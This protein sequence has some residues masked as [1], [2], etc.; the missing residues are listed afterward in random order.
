MVVKTLSFLRLRHNIC[1]LYLSF[2]NDV[3]DNSL[4]TYKYLL[5]LRIENAINIYTYK[6][7]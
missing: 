7:L 3:Y 6:Y 5:F 2:N 1:I 4:I